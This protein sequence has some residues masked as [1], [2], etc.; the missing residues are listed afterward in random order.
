MSES[1]LIF[2]LRKGDSK[3]LEEV[4]ARFRTSFL[5]WITH[6]HKCTKEEALDI[7]QYTILSFYENV[8]EGSFENMNEAGIKTY[9]YSIGKNK[10]LNDSR[11]RM[12]VT[13]TDTI[14][15]NEEPVEIESDV[16]FI[17][18]QK[19][20]KIKAALLEVGNP[21]KELLE[22]FYFNNLSAD[23]IAEVMDYKNGSTVRN[24]KY[25]CIQRIRKFLED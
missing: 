14:E 3:A 11:R 16:E 20:E 5:T 25:K 1:S 24:V 22:L 21:C 17:K 6:T 13:Y 10:L 8:V 9:L 4:Y 12:K 18:S 23:E 7:Y 15:D 2:R 19:I